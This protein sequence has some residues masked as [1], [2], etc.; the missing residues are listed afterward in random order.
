MPKRAAAV[1]AGAREIVMAPITELIPYARNARTHSDDQVEMIAASIR[2]YG[3]NAPVLTDGEGGILAG[4]GRVLA[5]ER[6]GL[7]E[8]PTVPLGHLNAEQRRAY[9]LADNRIAEH[10]GWD[11]DLLRIELEALAELEVDLDGLGFDADF[12][13]GLFDEAV[14][15]EAEPE[16][17]QGSETEDDAPEPEADPVSRPGDIWLLGEHRLGCGDSTDAAFVAQV[18]AD[19]K[20]GL[21]VTDPPYG[22]AYDPDWRNRAEGIGG[23]GDPEKARAGAKSSRAVGT[24]SNDDRA[25]WREAWELFPGDIA[26]IWHSALHASEVE[27]SL[28][29]AKFETRAQII[30]AKSS[31]VISRGHYHWK[32]EPCWYA[33]RKGGTANWK[34]D[35][36]QAT[37]WEISHR[38]SPTGHGTQKPVEAMRRPILNHTGPGDQVYDPFLGSGT[39]PIAAELTG[40]TCFGLELN[41]AY[42]DVII[43]RWQDESGGLATHAQT[44]ETF[45]GRAARPEAAD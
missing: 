3:F 12:M 13:A 32:H 25:D 41:P 39:T 43:R 24:V 27:A 14:G 30:W 15:G 8:V 45:E 37:V 42:C 29:A 34:G 36:K 10:A 40:R 23:W 35:R 31:I 6:A 20:P 28:M 21:M 26:Y 1:P 19:A 17:D 44:G 11:E 33:V 7:A 22:V 9:I 2:R 5:A 16:P 18:L 38:R 4:H